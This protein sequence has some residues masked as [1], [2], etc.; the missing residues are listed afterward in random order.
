M[1]PCPQVEAALAPSDAPH[2][3][4]THV[5]NAASERIARKAR[6]ALAE[7]LGI[8]SEPR[9]S[10]RGTRVIDFVDFEGMEGLRVE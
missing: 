2:W 5:A 7:V 4:D 6:E 8:S 9:H 10:G 3:T 1:H